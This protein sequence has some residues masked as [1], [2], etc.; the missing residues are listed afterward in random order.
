MQLPSTYFIEDGDYARLKNLQLGY[1]LTPKVL[2]KIKVSSLRVYFQAINL[3]TIT[4][5]SGLD[6][7]VTEQ[8]IDNSVYPT[9][10]IFM[11]GL[12]MKL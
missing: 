5:Y 4:K 6:P 2:S 7:E 3:F 9:S 12:N 11:F 1:T 10:R 8:G